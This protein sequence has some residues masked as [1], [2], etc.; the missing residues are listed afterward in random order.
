MVKVGVVEGI[1]SVDELG[2]FY[3]APALFLEELDQERFVL[4]SLVKYI[5]RE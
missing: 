3:F 5:A 1:E 4:F 2:G